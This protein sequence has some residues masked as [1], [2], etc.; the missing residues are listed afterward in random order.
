MELRFL[1]ADLDSLVDPDGEAIRAALERLPE[2]SGDLP[3]RAVF[4]DDNGKDFIQYVAKTEG[5]SVRNCEVQYCIYHGPDLKPVQYSRSLM[6]LDEV[7][8]LFQQYGSGDVSW[9]EKEHWSKV[10]PPRSGCLS[11]CSTTCG[12]I[13]IIFSVCGLFHPGNGP[14]AFLSLIMLMLFGGLMVFWH[15]M[16]WAPGV[17]GTPWTKVLAMSSSSAGGGCSS[18][19]CG[20]CGGSGGGGGDGGGDGGS[21]GGCGGGGE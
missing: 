19:S 3:P 15:R 11:G 8:E 18:G 17:D 6:A 9:R 2:L 10:Y 7:I 21:C 4:M 14:D 16:P 20:G 1:S 5:D 12:W 13:L